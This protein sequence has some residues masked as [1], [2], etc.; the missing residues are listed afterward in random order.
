MSKKLQ[1]GRD[2]YEYSQNG[3]TPGWGEDNSAW[4]EAVTDALNDVKGPN[5][6]L[7]TSA[8]LAN[9]QT[10]FVDIVGLTFN[11]AQVIY[12]N[13]EFFIK[14][15]SDNGTT[16]ITES[17]TII[18]NFDGSEFYISQDSVGASGIEIEVTSTGQFQYKSSDLADHVSSAIKFKANTL[19]L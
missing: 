14:R 8:V 11:T 9:N 5:D 18:G 1:V 10:D 15:T 17:G 4:A 12:V 13:V 19:D 3:E 7:A 6:I 2:V 16:T